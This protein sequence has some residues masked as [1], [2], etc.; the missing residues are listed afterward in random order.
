MNPGQNC[1]LSTAGG[2]VPGSF[3][4]IARRR[5]RAVLLAMSVAASVLGVTTAAEAQRPAPLPVVLLPA[6]GVNVAPGILDASRD[7]LKDHLQRTGLYT[8]LL[9]P[10]T[11]SA[12]EPTA[13]AA[14]QQA[15]AAHAQQA[16][17]LRLTHLG[18]STRVRMTVYDLSGRVVYWDS[19]AVTG[20]PEEMDVV[21]ERLVHAMVIGQPVR[22]SAELDTVT[23]DEMSQ[24]NRRTANRTFGLHLFTLLPFNRPTTTDSVSAVPGVGLFWMYD[25]RSW[26][27]DIAVDV[28][29]HAGNTIVD[30]ALGAYYPFFRTDFT[31]YLGGNVKYGY[32]SYGGTGSAGVSLQPTFG[33]LLGRTSSVQV[34]AEVG[35]F[36]DTFSEASHPVPNGAGGVIT[37]E[38][39]SHGL[40]MTVG[41]G[42]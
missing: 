2:V 22:D 3:R 11:S 31:P 24:L 27:A 42:F 18:T 40:A 38:R 1:Q 4:G 15:E 41:L 34:R 33:I 25:A 13:A 17:V 10:G 29:G 20:G 37:S 36:V 14:V 39:F 32:F 7:L 16:V 5:R 9:A 28:G 12:E 26:M 19:M 35:Y 23:S 21:L 8:V 6:S 30:V